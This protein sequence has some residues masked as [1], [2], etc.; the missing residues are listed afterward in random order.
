LDKIIEELLINGVIRPST[1]PFASPTLLVKKKDGSWRVCVDYRKLNEMTIKNK[2]P[3][4]IIDDLLDEYHGAVIFSKIDLKAGYH[5][6]RMHKEDVAKTALRTHEGHFEYLV[7]PF[8]LTN[9]P[10][11]FQALM[12]QIFKP[13]LRKFVLVFFDD[14]LIYSSDLNSHKQHLILVLQRLKEHQLCAKPSKCEFGAKKIKYLGH[15]ISAAGVATDLGKVEAMKDWPVPNNVRSLRGFL[16]L[17]GYYRKFIRGYG[18]ISKPL[19]DLLKKNAFQWNSQ[20]SVAFDT[21]KQA[22]STAPVLAMPGFTQPFILETDASDKGLGAVL[23]QGK[24]PIAY[25]S[26]ALGVKNQGLSTYE[27]ELLAVLTAVQK[28]RHY[29]YGKPFIIKTDHISLKHLLEQRLTHSLQH[30]GLCKLLGLDYVIQYKKR[31]E[32]RAADA[33]SRRS[34]D[35]NVEELNAVTEVLPLWL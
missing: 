24:R 8:G 33:L 5:Q 26:K 34:S 31:I 20:A 16:G 35:N 28:S 14:I 15:V 19:T 23:I 3:I 17:A 11:T 22:L 25:L 1:N 12:N 32:N 9:A 10:A 27:K 6:I 29:L 30:K 18:L 2:Y 7:M 21:L 4:P 13:Y